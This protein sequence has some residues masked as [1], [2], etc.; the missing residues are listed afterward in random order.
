[1]R[2]N[3]DGYGLRDPF[4]RR[5]IYMLALSINVCENMTYL[6]Y[7]FSYL[8]AMYAY[9]TYQPPDQGLYTTTDL[10]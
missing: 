2:Y 1:M 6:G 7:V 3:S 4:T 8:R 5:W 10:H 9:Y